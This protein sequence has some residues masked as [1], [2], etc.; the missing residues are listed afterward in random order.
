MQSGNYDNADDLRKNFSIP[1][2]VLDSSAALAFE[3]NI[4]RG[5]YKRASSLKTDYQIP[6]EKTEELIIN[7]FEAK[8]NQNN[9]DIAKIILKFFHLKQEK[10][11]ILISNMV[12]ELAK[13]NL[14]E[15]AAYLGNQFNLPKSD[16]EKIEWKVFDRK[17]AQGKFYEAN[18]ISKKYKLSPEK[19]QAKIDYYVEQLEQKGAKASADL[20]KA[21]FKAEKK[22]FFRKLLG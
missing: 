6:D 13:K 19:I 11:N 5:N 20:I 10:I 14:F 21:H 18:E 9:I 4:N 3:F 2:D 7:T 17:M 8:L 22:G 16:L 1:K 12:N 15:K